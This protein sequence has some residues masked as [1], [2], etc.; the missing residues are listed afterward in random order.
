MGLRTPNLASEDRRPTL[1]EREPEAAVHL[2]VKHI[3]GGGSRRPAPA[4]WVGVDN[5]LYHRQRMAQEEG[6]NLGDESV[7][8]PSRLLYEPRRV[9]PSTAIIRFS[10]ISCTACIQLK[11]HF[12]KAPGSRRARTRRNVSSQGR[13]LARSSVQQSPFM[14]QR[15]CKLPCYQLPDM[16]HIRLCRGPKRTSPRTDGPFP[17]DVKRP[18][19]LSDGRHRPS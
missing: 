13:P 4:L 6:G 19:T 8:L 15:L 1:E 7:A 3:K 18:P 16:I 12:S 17:S 11:R 5:P 9:L 10:V 14:H 2:L